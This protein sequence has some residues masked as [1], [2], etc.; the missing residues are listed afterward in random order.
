M[1]VLL[2]TIKLKRGN[3]SAVTATSLERGEPAVAMDTRSLWIGD[4]TGKIKISDI[5]VSA[6][7]ASLPGTGEVNKLYMVITDEGESNET[8]LYA[9]KAGTYVLVTSGAGNIAAGDITDLDDAIDNRVSGT[10]RGQVDG[11][12]PLDSGSKIPS[13]YLPDLSITSV[14]VVADNTAR[15]ALTV[16]AGDVAI[17]TGTNISWIYTGS[18]WT[19]MLTA[20]DGIVN[21]NG[22][23]GP[24]VTLNTSHV[25]EVTNL[26]FTDARAQ[27][28]VID[29]SSTTGDTDVGW[30]ANKLVSELSAHDNNLGSLSI[31][32]GALGDGKLI[33]YNGT[34]GNLEYHAIVIDGG[35]L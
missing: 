29:D 27:S 15:D 6:D 11:V 7:Y 20:V 19:E 8:T 32:E 35:E 9:W 13:S 23:T 2:D 21:V 30:S 34:S 10:W 18:A 14:S 31:D 4:G 33:T 5:V 22:Q 24:T 17:V 25:A 26:Y 16:Q 1:T 12:A 3:Q 28:A